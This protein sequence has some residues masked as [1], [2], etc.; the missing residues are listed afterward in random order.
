VV[1][2]E[3]PLIALRS[4][5]TTDVH[6]HD[7][8]VDSDLYV[9][10]TAM[11]KA[12]QIR[13]SECYLST[14]MIQAGIS[15]SLHS[16]A[17]QPLRAPS[18][19]FINPAASFFYDKPFELQQG[20]TPSP[21]LPPPRPWL[22]NR[23]AGTPLVELSSPDRRLWAGYFTYEGESVGLDPPM[24]LELYSVEGPPAYLRPDSSECTHFYGEGHD[25]VGT[26]SLRGTCDSLTGL[27]SATKAYTTHEWKWQGMMTPFGMAG[28]WSGGFITG[29]WWIW[30]RE[31]SS[32]PA[33]T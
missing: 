9:L 33:T 4:F 6:D 3:F 8:P 5:W 15:M 19:P 13:I 18:L 2:G 27:V 14:F 25:G 32:N 31:W 16:G 30:P 21:P 24:F 28:V 17:S 29:C 26:F 1:Y 10:L 23:L 20:T 7:Y 11:T 12:R 22:R